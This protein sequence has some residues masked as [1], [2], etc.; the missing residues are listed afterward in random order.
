MAQFD[1]DIKLKV[2]V[3][4]LEASVRKVEN[5]FK[6]VQDYRVKLKVDGQ[7]E[8]K[9]LGNSFKRLGSIIKRTL[10]LP[11]LLVQYQPA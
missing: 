3:E 5:A 9:S 11:A 10:A 7:N 2:A 1:A 6:K 8:L 4:N